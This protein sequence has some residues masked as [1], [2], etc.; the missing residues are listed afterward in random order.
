ME[1]RQKSDGFRSFRTIL[2]KK[3]NAELVRLIGELYGL[4][5]E[6]QRFLSARLDD[7]AKHKD[8]YKRIVADAMFPDPLRKGA[9]VRIADAKKAI[10]Q[11]ERA[12]GD[13]AG[14]IDLMLTFVEQGT[15]FTADLGY[16]EDAFFSSLETML[17]RT[18]E[19]LAKSSP[20]IRKAIKPRLL[21]L[22]DAAR[23]I[24]WGYGDF[25]VDAV[26][27]AVPEGE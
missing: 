25:V 22:R 20:A 9:E 23:G 13:D 14:T 26:D 1:P 3:S 18:L 7:P 19:R 17:S 4:S 11:Y 8:S 15:A 24:G 21:S 12:A 6:N 27:R 2:L 5:R 16:R 10:S